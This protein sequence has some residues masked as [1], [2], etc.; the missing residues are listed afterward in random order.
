M[1]LSGPVQAR[2]GG[3]S[4]RA[5]PPAA[6]FGRFTGPILLT[7]KGWLALFFIAAGYAKL[8][9]PAD[10][11]ANLMIWPARVDLA[12]VRGLGALEIGAT[13]LLV[14]PALLD[15]PSTRTAALGGVCLLGGEA[16]AFGLWHAL[17]GALT[18]VL[19]DTAVAAVCGGIVLGQR[20]PPRAPETP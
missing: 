16:A 4:G 3:A 20:G 7:L 17:T 12:W 18:L 2:R 13:L 10:I 8:S 19:T 9:Q 1:S 5:P 6:G 14:L 11:L 15:R